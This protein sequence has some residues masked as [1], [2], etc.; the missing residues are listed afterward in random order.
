MED[1]AVNQT[2]I[3]SLIKQL[4][5]YIKQAKKGEEAFGIVTSQHDDFDN[6]FNGL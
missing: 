1:N 3:S 6:Y 5:I 2:I 4:G